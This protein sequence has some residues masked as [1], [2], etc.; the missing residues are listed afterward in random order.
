MSLSR[1]RTLLARRAAPLVVAASGG[2]CRPP[3][4]PPAQPGDL[5]AGT[6]AV[7]V[8]GAAEGW[9]RVAF[10]E[11]VR[12]SACRVGDYIRLDSR[13]PWRRML[14]YLPGLDAP[15]AA[16]RLEGAGGRGGPSAHLNVPVAMNNGFSLVI[17]HGAVRVEAQAPAD[18]RGALD[19]RVVQRSGPDSVGA[20]GAVIRGVFRA[21]P[22][23]DWS[24]PSSAPGAA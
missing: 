1:L 7:T 9:R 2:A 16:Y 5:R 4:P 17:T 10:D 14:V 3:A 12:G 21:T 23:D 22:C 13:R 8:R 24:P 15:P 11:I 20:E 18:V 6:F 19:A